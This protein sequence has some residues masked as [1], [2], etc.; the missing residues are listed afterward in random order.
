MLL[1][2]LLSH[3]S[4]KH[5]KHKILANLALYPFII[6]IDISLVYLIILSF[7][8]HQCISEILD[9]QCIISNVSCSLVHDPVLSPGQRTTNRELPWRKLGNIIMKFLVSHVE[10]V[11]IKS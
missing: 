5:T 3:T 9:H 6:T 2:M 8:T 10:N 7:S 4:G 1:F 11:Y